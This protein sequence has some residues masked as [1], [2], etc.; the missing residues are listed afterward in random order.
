MRRCL[1]HRAHGFSPYFTI[2]GQEVDL[3]SIVQQ[4]ALEVGETLS[5]E[6]MVG[7]AEQFAEHMGHVR[8]VVRE[9]LALYD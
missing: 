1:V 6:E 2:F 5:D 7:L 9:C 3:P 4:E 8:D